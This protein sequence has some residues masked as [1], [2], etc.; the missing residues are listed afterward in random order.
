MIANGFSSHEMFFQH[1]LFF[2]HFATRQ[3][4]FLEK[5]L[6]HFLVSGV[7]LGIV[8]LFFVDIVSALITADTAGAGLI[9]DCGLVSSSQN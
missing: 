4:T 7:S 8:C 9:F 6:F 1:G 2:I 5:S 3:A